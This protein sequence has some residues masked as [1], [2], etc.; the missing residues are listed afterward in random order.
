MIIELS[1]DCGNVFLVDYDI[2]EWHAR[3]RR[4]ETGIVAQSEALV[5]S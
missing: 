5:P 3:R 4:G 1:I 2:V